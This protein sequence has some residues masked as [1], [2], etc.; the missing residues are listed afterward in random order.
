MLVSVWEQEVFYAPCDIAIAGAGL[1]GLWT[2]IEA[3]SKY[4]ALKITLIE[5]SAIPQGASTRNAGFACF[6]SPSE[7]LHD[8]LIDEQSMWA[9]AAMRYQ[10]IRKIRETL[11]DGAVGYDDCGGYECLD[12]G[13]ALIPE[14]TEKLHWLNA[15]MQRITGQINTFSLSSDKLQT[16][17]LSGFE[18]LIENQCEGGVHSGK[19]IQVLLH[20]A[21]ELGVKLLWATECRHWQHKSN[22]GIE[23]LLQTSVSVQTIKMQCQQ[24]VMAT[25]AYLSQQFAALNI[26]PARGQMLLTPAIEGL[27]LRGTFHFD[28]GYYYFRN[29]GRRILVGGARNAAFAEEETLEMQVTDKIQMRLMAFLH[30][31]IPA[32]RHLKIEDCTAWSGLMAMNKHKQPLLQQMEPGVWAAM[33]CN[34][35]GV[36]LSPVWAEKVAKALIN[37]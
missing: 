23:L 12:K 21:Q 28:E 27:S 6:G 32:S 25:N 35:M 4:P 13:N 31:H 26:K 34:G 36:A 37:L 1:L 5:Q 19:L 16:F 20:K 7:M 2:A 3:K 18:A 30:Q 14:L 17:G 15:G 24:L 9:T 10:G 11:G 29:M 33:C 22:Q 8:A